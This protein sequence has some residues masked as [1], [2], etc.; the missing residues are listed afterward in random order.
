M[1]ATLK[2][3]N[4]RLGST[5][6]LKLYNTLTKKKEVFKPIKGKKVRMY[7]CGPT[8]YN[9]IHIGN[10]RTFLTFDILK[11][12]LKFKGYEVFHVQNIT[13]VG[14]LTEDDLHEDKLIRKAKEE[15]VTPIQIAEHYTEA[16][17]RDTDRLNIQRPDQNPKATEHIKEMIEAVQSLIKRG[18]AYE[19]NG[20]IYYDVSSFKNYGKLSKL[21]RD[22]LLAGA[23]VKVLEEKHHPADFA[24]WKKAEPGHAMHWPSPWGEGYPGWH[25]ECSVMSAKYLGMPF[26]IHG[27][28]KDLIFPHHENEIAQAE[29]E[30]DT[31]FCR[32]W[33]HSEF[34]LIN[35]EK[36]SKS[37]GNFFTAEE[38]MDKFGPEA[39]RFFLINSHYRTEINLTD[40]SLEAAKNTLARFQ[41]FIVRLQSVKDGKSNPKVKKF[42][43]KARS[44]F[45]EAM[46]DDLNISEALGHLFDF[47][48]AVNVLIQDSALSEEN[49]V[50]VLEFLKEIDAVLGVMHF[51]EEELEEKFAKLITKRE[52][53]RKNKDYATGDKIRDQLKKRGIIIEDTPEGTRWKRA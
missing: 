51:E 41:D 49:A 33:I 40:D 43:G 13:D 37:K 7:V 31:Q 27:G 14:H 16:Y 18:H 34:L 35:N 28:G 10:A 23:R 24:L 3:R 4:P 2:N 52:E 6:A 53:A 15:K 47:I 21:P 29:G 12:Y 19:A 17:F 26:D 44:A 48:R 11:R 36:M 5:V 38:I 30:V 42:V 25:I 32:V 1:S 9:Y 8:V 50:S 46:D 39:T 22:Q 45:E 20:N